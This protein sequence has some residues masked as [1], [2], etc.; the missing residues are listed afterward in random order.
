ML[1]LEGPSRALEV[2]QTRAVSWIGGAQLSKLVVV[3]VDPGRLDS[4]KTQFLAAE[5]GKEPL[6][7]NSK[8][9]RWTRK[10]EDDT[11]DI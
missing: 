10:V 9:A 4:A 6:V 3:P 2:V 5:A 7:G 11:Q 8:L 1:P